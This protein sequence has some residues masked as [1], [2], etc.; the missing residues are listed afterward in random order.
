MSELLNRREAIRLCRD[1][2]L[3]VT[4]RGFSALA[5]R[6]S[7]ITGAPPYRRFGKYAFYPRDELI[8]WAEQAMTPLAQSAKEH[9]Q[10]R[11]ISEAA[12]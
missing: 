4:E 8:K 5:W 9:K 1:L 6:P 12:D 10:A 11:E 3:P 7:K 2:G